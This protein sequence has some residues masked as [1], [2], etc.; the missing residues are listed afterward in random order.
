MAQ[1]GYFADLP[2]ASE[3]ALGEAF[4]YV[5]PRRGMMDLQL[6]RMSTAIPAQPAPSRGF[7][8]RQLIALHLLNRA[9]L[10]GSDVRL[11]T[12][13]LVSGS[14]F[15]RQPAP[16]HWWHWQVILQFRWDQ[17]IPEHINILET[18]AAFAALRWRA[19][20][21]K[22]HH[23]KYIHLLDSQ[24]AI[25]VLAKHRSNSQQLQ[26]VLRRHCAVELAA[27]LHPAYVFVPSHLNP[28]DA[29]SRS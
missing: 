3:V 18:R 12:S 14:A 15:P 21:A 24:V 10:K 27:S 6:S 20:S 19:R 23:S 17:N 26:R 13:E 16:V 25:A 9:D 4:N 28:A 22:N 5:L 1:L 11:T 7:D 29:P 8:S 2:S